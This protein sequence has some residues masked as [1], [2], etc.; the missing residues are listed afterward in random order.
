MN[1]RILINVAFFVLLG[2][3]LSAW[4]ATTLLRLDVIERPFPVTAEFE[5]SPGLFPDLQVTYLGVPV[6]RVESVALL[7]GKVA[8]RME[9]E[10]DAKVPTGAGARVLRKSAVGEPY[11][12]LTAPTEPGDGVLKA[13]DTVPLTRTSA[14]VD[15][16][17]LFDGLGDTLNAVDPADAQVLIHELATGVNGRADTLRD[18]IGDTDQL[19]AT[20]AANSGLLDRLATELTDVTGTLAAHRDHI[21]ATASDL[22]DVTAEVRTASGD[23]VT[24][25][26]QG[27]GFL[28]K[29]ETLL[30]TSRPG[31][32]CLLTAG[33]APGPAIFTKQ[34]EATVSHV[35]TLLP[36][37]EALLEDTAVVTPQATYLR[38]TALVSIAGPKAAADY[39]LPLAKPASAAPPRCP[40]TPGAVSADDKKKADAPERP[41]EEPGKTAAGEATPVPARK[42]AG[43]EEDAL[44]G[45]LP[46]LPV[47]LSAAVLAAVAARTIRTYWSGRRSG[48]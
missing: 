43:S 34:T 35:L 12:E 42:V 13:G 33:A 21:A 2:T 23:L 41:E 44:D 18:L 19:T 26:E 7:P 14:S 27:P 9:L 30:Q 24:V 46:L 22:S 5:S 37:F 31:L 36:T 47:G 8:V 28:D 48:H 39:T 45:I 3:V 1:R 10:H 32:G 16:Q 25:L 20:L 11:I 40:A 15:Y 4:A 6:G 17:E 29:V 38:A